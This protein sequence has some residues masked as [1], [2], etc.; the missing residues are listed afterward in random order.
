MQWQYGR[1]RLRQPLLAVATAGYLALVGWLTLGPQP[2]DDNGRGLLHRIIRYL[3]GDN[4]LDW[5]T[6]ALVEFT[7]N[8][9]LFVPVGI[10]FALLLG[11]RRWWLAALLGVGLTA[12]I[13]FAQLFLRDRVTDPRDIVSNSIGA[14]IGVA[15]VLIVTAWNLKRSA[16]VDAAER[17]LVG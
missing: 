8:I 11:W 14:F 9:V 17:S 10:L 12:S 15:L 16:R 7:A 5:I 3:S 13:E 6:Y 1:M 2:L 4:K